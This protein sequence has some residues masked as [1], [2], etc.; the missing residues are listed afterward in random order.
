[1]RAAVLLTLVGAGAAAWLAARPS[2]SASVDAVACGY[3]VRVDGVLYCDDE[4]PR[5]VAAVCPGRSGALVSGDA[6]SRAELCAEERPV[7]GGPG[8]GKLGGDD[9]DALAVPVELNDATL[10]E[11]ESLPGIGPALAREIVAGRPYGAVDELRR[12]PGIGPARL[13]AVRGRVR[14]TVHSP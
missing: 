14:V 9:L 7:R 6:L 10:A 8:W 5:D 1:M 3:A 13:A 4:A 2:P 12:V 11:L